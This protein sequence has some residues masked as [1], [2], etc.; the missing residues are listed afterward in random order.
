MNPKGFT[1]S[2]ALIVLAL[3]GVIAA[4]L[5]PKLMTTTGAQTTNAIVQEAFANTGELFMRRQS[6]SNIA[7]V[8]WGGEAAT[9]QTY[10]ATHLNAPAC[11]DGSCIARFPSGARIISVNDV[12]IRPVGSAVN[13]NGL[14]VTLNAPK[15]S[16]NFSLVIVPP[17]VDPTGLATRYSTRYGVTGLA[18]DEIPEID[19]ILKTQ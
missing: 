16:S 2:E 1:L 13:V 17:V 3:M 15:I 6:D 7:A 18:A 19:S 8:T 10:I 5:I 12:S 14:S 4:M 11:T 9:F